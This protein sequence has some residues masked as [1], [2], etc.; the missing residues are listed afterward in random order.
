[1]SPEFRSVVGT[2]SLGL[3]IWIF[4]RMG[5][6]GSPKLRAPRWLYY[7]CLVKPSRELS[8]LATTVQLIAFEVI[9]SII[10]AKM[11]APTGLAIAV[12]GVIFLALLV[13]TA[14]ALRKL[15]V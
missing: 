6:F 4:G 7:I 3:V 8:Y 5:Q 14:I 12:Q 15:I 10:L 13:L 1:M 9:F 11:I 2:F